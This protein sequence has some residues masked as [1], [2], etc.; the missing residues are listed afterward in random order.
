MDPVSENY[1]EKWD[2]MRNEY[3]AKAERLN[4]EKQLEYNDAFDDFSQEAS[5]A[6]DWTSA[7]WDEFV[8]RV[9]KKW[10]EL[11]IDNQEKE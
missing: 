10:Q 1:L 11:A 3:E 9:D 4:A 7:S 2:A 8:A 6:A 5:A